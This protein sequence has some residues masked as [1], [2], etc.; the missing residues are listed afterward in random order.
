MLE[1]LKDVWVH[2]F[3]L[4]LV[5]CTFICLR[6]LFFFGGG[7]G[8]S[9]KSGKILYSSC[10]QI[11]FMYGDFSYTTNLKGDWDK[12]KIR[13]VSKSGQVGGILFPDFYAHNENKKHC[14]WQSSF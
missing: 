5:Q 9:V 14:G 6:G 2:Y 1:Q 11:C 10:L 7:G 13:T 3:S 4:G 8:N 12:I